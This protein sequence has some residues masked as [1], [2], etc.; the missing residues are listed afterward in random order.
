MTDQVNLIPFSRSIIGGK[1][2]E[3]AEARLSSELKERMRRKWMDD[4][5]QSESEY[6]EFIVAVDVCGLEHV[7]SVI[8][9]R[10]GRVF[11]SSDSGQTSGMGEQ[12]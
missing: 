10:F 7:R 2:T 8:Q 5:F 12:Q 9:Q 6:I 4:G 3:K 11:F 1:K